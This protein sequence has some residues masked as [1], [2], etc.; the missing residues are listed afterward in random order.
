M[1]IKLAI[2]DMDGV[3]LDSMSYWRRIIVDD[4]AELIG[5]PIDDETEQ[6][7][8]SMS[9]ERVLG[10]IN[11]EFADRLDHELTVNGLTDI[12]LDRYL[13]DIQP[14]P[15]LV[16]RLKEYRSRCVPVVVMSA[17]PTVIC[18]QALETHNLLG[19]VTEVCGGADKSSPAG[20]TAAMERYGAHPDETVLY[21]DSL[22]SIRTGA[23]LGMHVV[24]VYDE[25]CCDD[26]SELKAAVEEYIEP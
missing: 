10:Y 21:E 24:G 9:T 26:I 1:S 4:A 8:R 20:F 6:Q 18:R 3:I 11:T 16:E 19:F 2:F 14:K 7:L 22:Y 15:K 25:S 17:T 23:A 5:I 12:I 13:H